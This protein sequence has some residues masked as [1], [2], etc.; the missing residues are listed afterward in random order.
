[1]SELSDAPIDH[2]YEYSR[3]RNSDGFANLTMDELLEEIGKNSASGARK[4]SNIIWRKA[5]GLLTHEFLLVQV[6]TPG[7]K[8]VW[9]RLERAAKHNFAVPANLRPGS[10]VSR[11]YPDDRVSVPKFYI[12]SNPYVYSQAK[13]AD[14]Q[15]HLLSE[16]STIY[17]S[18]T[19]DTQQPTLADLCDLLSCFVGVSTSYTLHKASGHLYIITPSHGYTDYHNL[20][21]LLVLL[22]CYC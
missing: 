3:E 10:L 11:F 4:I 1:L 12:D 9:L 21:E 2:F 13:I 6:C 18:A 14:S 22:L 16:T 15:N 17:S 19:F 7:R 5:G 20:G 8:D